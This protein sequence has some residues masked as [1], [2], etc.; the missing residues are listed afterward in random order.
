MPHMSKFMYLSTCVL[1]CSCLFLHTYLLFPDV[2]DW[3]KRVSG[4]MKQDLLMFVN[5][6][7]GLRNQ[8]F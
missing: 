7:V 5:I 6:E 4:P 2:H 3:Q 8:I 1:V